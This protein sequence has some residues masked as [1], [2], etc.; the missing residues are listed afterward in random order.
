M[1]KQPQLSPLDMEEQQFFSN[2][3]ELPA[4]FIS[5]G[6]A[7]ILRK[8]ILT[9]SIWELCLLARLPLH[10]EALVLSFFFYIMLHCLVTH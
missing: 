1:P 10:S 4:L 2:L 3:T 6:Q 5:L 8:V 9:T 7:T